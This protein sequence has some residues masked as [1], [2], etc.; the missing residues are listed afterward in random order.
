MRRWPAGPARG[1]QPPPPVQA[2]IDDD[3]YFETPP[4][5]NP[6][7]NPNPNQA[8][9]D[10]YY[11]EMLLDELPIWGYVGELETKSVSSER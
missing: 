6:H 5:P 9:I 8:I 2:I 4:N 1:S 10:D 11:F 7:P 3:C